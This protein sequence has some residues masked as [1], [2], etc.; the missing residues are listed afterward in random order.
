[1]VKIDKPEAL[2]QLVR[3]R[4]YIVC[5]VAAL[6]IAMVAIAYFFT[7][8]ITGPLTAL[9]KSAKKIGK[10]DSYATDAD[11][12]A[13]EPGGDEIGILVSVFNE[14]AD[15][16]ARNRNMLTKNLAELAEGNNRLNLLLE[17]TFEGI[18]IAV[19]GRIVDAN[20]RCAEMF[21]YAAAEII[22]MPVLDT[23]APQYR[24]TVMKHVLAGYDK[25]YE[26][27]CL[28]KDGTVIRIEA[29]GKSMEYE[30]RR[31]RMV[32]LRD[33][34]ERKALEQRLEAMNKHLETRVKDEIEKR[35][36]K[37]NLLIQQSKMAAMGEMIAAIAHQWKQPLNNLSLFVQDLRDAYKF[38]ELDG[39]YID[40]S[41]EKSMNE[42]HFM[43]KT[44]EE[45]RNFFKPSIE[46]ETCDLIG[47]TAGV[48]SMISEQLKTNSIS[49]S[50]TCHTHN[51]TFRS[52]SEVTHCDATLITTYKNQLAHVILN[53]INNARDAIIQRRRL[54]LSDA[55]EKG[56]ANTVDG[57]ISVDCKR[58]GEIMQLSISD[59]GGGIPEK[60]M[61]RIFEPYF[62]TKSEIEGTGI[63][64]YMS[65]IIVEDKLGGRIAVRNIE[66]GAV[67]TLEFTI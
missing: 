40:T 46:K 38:G 8:R 6:T 20:N 13:R 58:C 18:S 12:I 34:T 31:V 60:I 65:K 4:K 37:E 23:V 55:N 11:K 57:S 16:I 32:A 22:G 3:I 44:I 17:A 14:M 28:K 7:G 47:V 67:F 10:G 43:A 51:V 26:M 19:D 29:C 54:G 56:P 1:M 30:G 62:T 61:G 9:T 45:F 2:A 24:E 5:G 64:L 50:I 39:A 59:N 52:I 35:M 33:I 27:D 48:L 42:I 21:G 63:G 53:I 49:Y 15:T 41:V 66:G 25:P 36:H